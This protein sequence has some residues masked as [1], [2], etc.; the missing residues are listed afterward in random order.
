[1]FN[2]FLHHKNFLL[3]CVLTLFLSTNT[4]HAQNTKKQIKALYIPLADHYAAVVAY[5]KYR[6]KMIHADF[7]IQQMKNWD[8]LRAYFQSGEV[9]MAY[10][11]S[12][13]A[14]DMYTEKAH[15]RWIGLMHRDGNALAINDIIKQ[16]INL[17][18][19][20][21][22][23]K[24]DQQVAKALNAFNQSSGKPIEIGMPHL[25]ATHTVVLYRY[26]KEHGLTLSLN[27]NTQASVL[28]ISLAPP[29]A[30]AFIK[31]K[32]IRNKAAAFEQSLPWADVVETGG[33]GHVAWYSKDVMP[34]ENGH[35]ECIA[36][37]TNHA[38]SEKFE[39]TQEVMN[40]IKL[41]GADIEQART[42]GGEKLA[43]IV[44]II[45]KHIPAHT[46]EAIIASLDP[47][48]R[49]I[50]YQSLNI[51]KP[52]LAQIMNLAV[53]GNILKQKINIDEFSDIRFDTK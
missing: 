10:V 6:D 16:K 37:A 47:K 15:F 45:R 41:A 21:I 42:Q 49:V 14:M 46:K 3:T 18:K 32:S 13:L 9:D 7:Q 22:D 20:R 5:E 19:N 4:T 25:L 12:P 53:E 48:L 39:A 27:S 28:A 30:P 11:M 24:P 52:G 50:N 17:A 31:S 8:L 1:M 40:Y 26:L 33:F 36:L 51:D 2:C 29:K 43:E 23:R 34:W 38:I 44:K 35:V